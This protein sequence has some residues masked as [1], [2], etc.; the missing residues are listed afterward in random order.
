MINPFNVVGSHTQHYLVQ[1]MDQSF[2]D[3]SL[4]IVYA[5]ILNRRIDL[6]FLDKV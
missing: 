2:C 6:E 1:I 4:M 5:V 3:L